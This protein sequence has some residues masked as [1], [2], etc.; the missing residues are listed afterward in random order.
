MEQ[1]TDIKTEWIVQQLCEHL[2]YESGRNDL[3]TARNF[4]IP[5]K[6]DEKEVVNLVFM[7][8]TIAADLLDEEGWDPDDL[9]GLRAEVKR[10]AL[11]RISKKNSD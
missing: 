6:Y 3:L 7:I 10:R 1:V 2:D 4:V 9:E 8:T 11:E 5:D